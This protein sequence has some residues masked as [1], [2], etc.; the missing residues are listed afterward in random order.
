MVEEAKAEEAEEAAVAATEAMPEE[1][2]L[3]EEVEAEV[4]AK[5][6]EEPQPLIRRFKL[7]ERDAVTRHEVVPANSHLH[8]GFGLDS[9]RARSASML[10]A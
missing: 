5:E 2:R 4:G 6:A 10:L 3:V 7:I 1:E 9:H 8:L